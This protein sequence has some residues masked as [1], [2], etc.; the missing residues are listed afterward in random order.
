[1]DVG[2]MPALVRWLASAPGRA[3]WLGFAVG[4]AAT[5][6]GWAWL[7]GGYAVGAFGL[8]ILAVNCTYRLLRTLSG[9]AI[10][11]HY[12]LPRAQVFGSLRTR[13]LPA[14]VL[15]VMGLAMATELPL[16]LNVKLNQLIIGRTL[17]RMWAVDP[18]PP[19][20]VGPRMMGLFLARSIDVRAPGIRFD[21]LF[22]G[23]LYFDPNGDPQL[24]PGDWPPNG[25]F[26]DMLN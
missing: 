12:G 8:G 7:P 26:F 21:V 10:V 16:F 15:L 23:E 22:A 13:Y 18:M 9:W 25:I 2:A 14:L 3:T 19:K 1:M 20:P 24:V 6:W 4:V 17:Y 11:F 5:L